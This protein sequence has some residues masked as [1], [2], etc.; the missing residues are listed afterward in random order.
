VLIEPIAIRGFCNGFCNGLFIEGSC[1]IVTIRRMLR[2]RSIRFLV[3]RL[4]TALFVVQVMAVGFC[5]FVP[6]VH[7]MT[8]MNMTPV[9]ALNS[10][11]LC[12]DDDL[13]ADDRHNAKGCFHCSSPDLATAFSVDQ[14]LLA[15]AAQAQAALLLFVVT[16]VAV[17]Q[18][19]ASVSK[20][21]LHDPGGS[22]NNHPHLFHLI[23]R[24]LV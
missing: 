15:Q 8:Q 3:V 11:V 19:D 5:L 10:A 18:P 16:D 2:S 17:D 12:A 21:N 20:W 4:I 1:C 22:A 14:S 23:P 9:V 6:Q 13:H 7:A 24:I